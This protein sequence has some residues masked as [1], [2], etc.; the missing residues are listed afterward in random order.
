M[1]IVLET[2]HLASIF[3]GII[4]IVSASYLLNIWRKQDQR[5]LTDLPLFFGTSFTIIGMNMVMMGFM[6]MG[7]IPDIMPIFRLRTLFLISG[8][9]LPLFV[10]ILHIWFHRFRK[11][12]KHAIGT[13]S[14]YWAI[15]SLFGP[16][17]EVIMILLVPVM[18]AIIFAVVVT[19]IITWRTGR[20]KEVRSDFIVVS[21]VLISM[22][23]IGKIVLSA[24]GLA[25]IAD[26]LTAFG[27]I[28]G[29][30]GLAN[31]W[32]RAKKKEVTKASP[33]YEEIGA[34]S[35]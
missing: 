10:A 19:F 28:V 24:A 30:I 22:G 13:L 31:P 29:A 27:I 35:I 18:I 26:I 6:N 9:V 5:L 14:A 7:I 17:T 12:F 33:E 1:Q 34:A 15:A 4:A 21:G 16:T 11:Y 32:F 8:S 2:S 25:Y 3:A 20:L 23:Q